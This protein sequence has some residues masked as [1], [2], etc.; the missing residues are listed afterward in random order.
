MICNAY[1]TLQNLYANSFLHRRVK[2]YQQKG[3]EVDIVV[4]TTKVLKDKYY[5][6]VHIKYMDEYQIASYF[7]SK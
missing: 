3:L 4:I 5:D 1:P 2:A 6:G 7:K